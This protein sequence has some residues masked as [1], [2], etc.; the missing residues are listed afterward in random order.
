M[1][2]R[3]LKGGHG[4]GEWLVA[5]VESRAYVGLVAAGVRSRVGGSLYGGAPDTDIPIYWV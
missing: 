3:G 4:L 1:Q 5:L 2:E